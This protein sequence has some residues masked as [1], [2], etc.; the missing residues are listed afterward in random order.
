MA[1]YR[2]RGPVVNYDAETVWACA[3]AVDRLNGGYCKQEEWT[4]DEETG[5][6][7]ITKHPNKKI[8]KRWLAEKTYD[9]VTEEDR[10]EGIKLRDYFKGYLMKELAGTLNDFERNVLKIAQMDE[11]TNRNVFE[12]AIISCLPNS[13][14]RELKN[15]EHQALL[16]ES[17]PIEGEIGDKIVGDLIVLKSYFNH[18]YNK[19]RIAGRFGESFVDF[20]FKENLDVDSTVRIQGKIKQHREDNSTQLNYVKKVQI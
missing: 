4:H 17:T 7:S 3:V 16:L 15:K 13:Y 11:L 2:N 10:D 1:R 9:A 18:N 12:F 5:E 20:W 6:A 19:F 8:V 14:R